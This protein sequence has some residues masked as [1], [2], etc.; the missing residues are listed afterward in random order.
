MYGIAL[1]PGNFSSKTALYEFCADAFALIV[2]NV[3]CI[4]MVTAARSEDSCIKSLHRNILHTWE[5][6][7]AEEAKWRGIIQ[8]VNGNKG[9]F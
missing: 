3:N 6:G 4:E 8:S 1:I 2:K 7:G 5:R 9:K